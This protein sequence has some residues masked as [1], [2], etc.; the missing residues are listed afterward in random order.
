MND[1]ESSTVNYVHFD[2]DTQDY[3]LVYIP[4]LAR[5]SVSNLHLPA[6]RDECYCLI[7]LLTRS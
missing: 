4:R 3:V 7:A 2:E 1:E 6:E 5:M